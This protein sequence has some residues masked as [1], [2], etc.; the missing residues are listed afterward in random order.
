MVYGCVRVCVCVCVCVCLLACLCLSVCLS[1]RVLG[2]EF[3]M[4]TMILMNHLVFKMVDMGALH[5]RKVIEQ[6]RGI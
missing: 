3:K 1:V 2:H 5:Q 4:A 6:T